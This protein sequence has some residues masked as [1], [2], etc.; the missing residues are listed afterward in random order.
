MLKSLNGPITKYEGKNYF[1]LYDGAD[2]FKTEVLYIKPDLQNEL[3]VTTGFRN[4][5]YFNATSGKKMGK[6]DYTNTNCD[7]IYVD[8]QK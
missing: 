3:L 5:E 2:Y 4:I 7:W 6:Q 8:C 1:S